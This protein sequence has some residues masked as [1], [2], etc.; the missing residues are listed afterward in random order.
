MSLTPSLNWESLSLSK[1][2]LKTIK[3]QF[4]FKCMTP[5]QVIKNY[6]T[7]FFFKRS[8]NI[9]SYYLGRMYKKLFGEKEGCCCRSSHR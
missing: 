1:P 9:H 4:K 8:M 5:I 2:V 6:Y 7:Y 3:E